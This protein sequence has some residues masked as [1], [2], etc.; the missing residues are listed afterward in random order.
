MT[1]FL[2]VG[3]AVFLLAAGWLF[4]KACERL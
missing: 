2:Y 3:A 1:V 4:V